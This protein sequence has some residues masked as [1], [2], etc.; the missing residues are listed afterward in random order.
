LTECA[1]PGAVH[2]I[3]YA[4]MQCPFVYLLVCCMLNG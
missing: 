1:Q 3:I 2:S 4:L